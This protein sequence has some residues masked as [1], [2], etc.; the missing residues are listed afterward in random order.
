[1][2]E[3]N[4]RTALI[5][6]LSG[7]A[8][9]SI[10]DALVKTMAGPWAGT[11]V[12]TLRYV[13]GAGGLTL[14]VAITEGRK[15]FRLPMPWLQLGRGA[16]VSLATICFFLGVMAMPLADATAIQFT[17]PMITGLLSAL[18]LGEKAPRAV[19]AA[20]ALAFAGVLVVLRPNVLALGAPAFFPLGAA[21]GMS[22]LMIC[23]RKAAGAAS[24]VAMQFLVAIMAAPILLAA[25]ALLSL[26]G[27]PQLAL[28]APPASVVVKCLVIACTATIAHL[29]IYMAAVRASAALVAPMTYVQLI[30][31]AILGWFLFGTAPDLSTFAG[32]ALIIGGGLLLWRSQKPRV[33]PEPE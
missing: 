5:L 4:T 21:L 3:H 29:L 2:A 12:A 6:A 28:H 9:L 20:T 27:A 23:N 13:A 11:A 8:T 14:V 26:T 33:V 18:L 30:V 22:V 25:T 32:A 24:P 19:W 7:F 10:G 17:S 31:A 16:G 1:M 15:G